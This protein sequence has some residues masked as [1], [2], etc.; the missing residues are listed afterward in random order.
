MN[1]QVVLF[2]INAGGT[3]FTAQDGTKYTGDHYVTGGNV[4]NVNDHIQGTQD[5]KLFKEERWGEFTYNFPVKAGTYSVTLHFAE[6]WFGN[7]KAGNRVFDVNIENM[8]LVDDLN[9]LETAGH[10][11]AYT[12]NIDDIVVSDGKLTL[13]FVPSVDQA[14]LRGI[15]VRGAM[16]NAL[17]EG[18]MNI[19]TTGDGPV[20]S[21]CPSAN[22]GAN[23]FVLFDGSKNIGPV[24]GGTIE[25]HQQWKL[26]EV[27]ALSSGA[28]I[29]VVNSAGGSAIE[30]SNAGIYTGFK[31]TPPL[32]FGQRS[33]FNLSGVDLYVQG[34]SS[35]AQFGV[36]VIKPGEF[37]GNGGASTTTWVRNAQGG[38]DFNLSTQ[39]TLLRLT[40][41]GN[42]SANQAAD[43]F[44]LEVKNG[45]NNSNNLKVRRMVIKDFKYVD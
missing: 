19:G 35:S 1:D 33:K 16:G 42:W 3:G 34:N 31:F 13:D 32:E 30:Y 5:Q 18:P 26:D 17:E 20:P 12:V 9:P 10:D 43:R 27:W 41:P 36:R 7:G 14:S 6:T 15:V 24:S 21:D 8:L 40:M 23:D 2:A 25:L 28:K 4:G 11:V 37:E 45:W 44:I 39:C 22:V 38:Q 29:Q